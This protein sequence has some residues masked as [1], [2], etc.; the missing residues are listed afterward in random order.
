[1]WYQSNCTMFKIGKFMNL[2]LTT[3]KCQHFSIF[4]Y[5]DREIHKQVG[6]Y[7]NPIWENQNR[8]FNSQRTPTEFSSFFYFYFYSSFRWMFI[9]KSVIKVKRNAVND[10][11]TMFVSMNSLS[12]N[13]LFFDI[14][15]FFSA[16]QF[17]GLRST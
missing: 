11:E 5:L 1:M 2:P 4:R 17:N 13:D 9:V 16:N 12:E 8:K 15:S 3:N 10:F 7:Y 6:I 14:V